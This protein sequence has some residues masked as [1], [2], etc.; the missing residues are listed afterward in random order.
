MNDFIVVLVVIWVCFYC[1]W[2][3]LVFVNDLED[4]FRFKSEFN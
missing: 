2:I 3:F 4:N 1:N